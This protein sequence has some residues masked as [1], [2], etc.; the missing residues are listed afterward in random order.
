VVQ[1][2]LVVP[3]KE[4][5]GVLE[6]VGVLVVGLTVVEVLETLELLELPEVVVVQVPGL[7]MALLVEQEAVLVPEVLEVHLLLLIQL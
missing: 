1:V 3:E 4:A 2:E 6:M 5:V 7:I